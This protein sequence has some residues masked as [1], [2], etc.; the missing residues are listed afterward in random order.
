MFMV[1]IV[2]IIPATP[3][4][5][6]RFASGL[7]LASVPTGRAVGEPGFYAPLRWLGPRVR[8]PR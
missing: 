6:V 1:R 3:K 4:I 2:G 8:R 7:R 5:S